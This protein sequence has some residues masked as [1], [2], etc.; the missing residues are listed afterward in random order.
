MGWWSP[1][2]QKIVAMNSKVFNSFYISNLSI[3][4][5]IL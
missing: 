4:K 3:G 2:L 5:A 1:Q